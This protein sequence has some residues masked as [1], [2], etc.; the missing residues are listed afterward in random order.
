MRLYLIQHGQALPKDVDPDRHLTD[1]GAADVKK[2]ADFLR[3]LKLSVAAIWHSG[4]PRAQQTAEILAHAISSRQGVVQQDGLAPDDPVGPVRKTIEQSKEDLM[5]VGHLPFLSKLTAALI[6]GDKSTDIV[7]FRYGGVVCLDR[8][9][10][11]RWTLA[12]L[13]LPD[14]LRP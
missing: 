14:L 10:G 2:V 4:K 11:N 1:P 6:T 7:T 13:I 9:D 12:W 5:I 8:T 3:P